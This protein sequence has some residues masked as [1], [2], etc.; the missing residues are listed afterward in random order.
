MSPRTVV[1]VHGAWHGAWCWAPLERELDALGIPHVTVDNPSVAGA[2]ADL[3]ADADNVLRTLDMIDGP[4]LLVGHSYGGAVITDAGVH[5]KVEHLVYISAFVLD[6]GESVMDNKLTG[7]EGMRLGEGIS[8]DGDV[9]GFD[10]SRAVEFFFHDCSETDADA[11]VARLRPMS[12]AAMGGVPRAI[13][14]RERPA[15]YIVCT[16][17]RALPVALQRSN[18]KRVANSVE[19]DAS[20]SPFLSQPAATAAILAELARA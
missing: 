16:D 5:P 2:P 19:L 15:T 8:F 11:A 3:A 17:D 4:V 1:L 9:L 12:L 18:A 14:W 20:H 7:G 13:A 6:A 10:A